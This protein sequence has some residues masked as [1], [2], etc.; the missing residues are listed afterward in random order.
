MLID[1]FT[2]TAQV[3]NFVVLMALLKRFLYK[4]ILSAMEER[5][6][7][8]ASRL[9]EAKRTR[10]EAEQERQSYRTKLRDWEERRQAILA[11]A[12]A[13]ANAQRQELIEKAR[14][15][16]GTLQEKWRRAVQWQQAAFLRDLSARTARQLYAIARRALQ[17]LANADIEQRLAEVFLEHLHKLNEERWR[18]LAVSLQAGHGVVTIYSAFDMPEKMRQIFLQLLQDHLPS[19]VKVEFVTRP[20]LI[21]GMELRT[22]GH[23]VSWSLE[24]YLKTL[25]DEVTKALERAGAEG[26]TVPSAAPR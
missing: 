23:K 11:E 5:E 22:D 20:D 18:A 2:V 12:K 17:D 19:G 9:A 4:P 16:V 21:C 26:E 1:W 6:R 8:I 7:N 24:Y 3:I 25:E 14:A 15:E 13:E 10:Q